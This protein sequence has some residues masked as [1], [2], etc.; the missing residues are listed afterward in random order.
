[1]IGKMVGIY[2]QP[3]DIG[4]I[5][6]TS[7]MVK[8]MGSRFYD[9]SSDI[10]IGYLSGIGFNFNNANMGIWSINF[11][12]TYSES[13][14][15]SIFKLDILG[16]SK[17]AGDSFGGY[18]KAFC[19]G[20]LNKTSGRINGA[21]RSITL[22]DG[23]FALSSGD[24][25]GATVDS[26]WEAVGLGKYE[27]MGTTKESDPAD[28]NAFV[29]LIE[30]SS[31]LAKGLGSFS[32]GKAIDVISMDGRSINF[33]GQEWGI[34]EANLG[35]TCDT[36][37]A[38]TFKTAIGGQVDNDSKGC[39]IATMTGTINSGTIAAKFKGIWLESAGDNMVN[40]GTMSG[41][42][43]GYVD[44]SEPKGTWNAAAVGEWVEVTD[45]L[46]T[47]ENKLR[48]NV[49]Q[50]N[51]FVS[52]PITEV[53]SNILTGAGSRVG[54]VSVTNNLN[55]FLNFAFNSWTNNKWDAN[56][57]GRAGAYNIAGQAGGTYN[58]GTFKGVGA[59][60]VVVEDRLTTLNTVTVSGSY[61]PSG[62]IPMSN[63]TAN[64]AVY[65]STAKPP[66]GPPV[67]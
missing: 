16:S 49:D 26:N 20:L 19:S 56:Y 55:D 21:I 61:V 33:R 28:E 5:S 12:G 64:V 52:V 24:M 50:L 40:A 45:L 48:F 23:N 4:P 31:F 58:D 27:R 53:Y 36:V 7:S 6:S 8:D 44:I 67:T 66:A 63:V 2:A 60:G 11:D 46:K 29:N 51:Q 59:G 35:G 42:A 37:I 47:D 34:W 57:S 15:M 13:K 17:D 10:K 18:W 25:L 39:I 22:Q 38:S 3:G 54:G 62:T 30:K 32:N 41:V 65:E 14:S 9:A 43:D 1:M